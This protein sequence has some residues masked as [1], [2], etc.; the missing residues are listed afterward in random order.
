M[1]ILFTGS[2]RGHFKHVKCARSQ[3]AHICNGLHGGC[4]YLVATNPQV[5]V[6]EGKSD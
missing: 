1:G 2:S 6:P 3:F 5:E 4:L